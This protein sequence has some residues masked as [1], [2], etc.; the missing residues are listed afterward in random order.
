[1]VSAD[2]AGAAGDGDGVAW[3]WGLQRAEVGEVG[4]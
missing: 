1:V 2:E 4:L 3:S